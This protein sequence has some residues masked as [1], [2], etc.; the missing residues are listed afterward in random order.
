MSYQM[1][2]LRPT[3]LVDDPN[4]IHDW[5]T[6]TMEEHS[7]TVPGQLV[8]SINPVTSNTQAALSM[9]FYLLQITVLVA[10]TASLFQSFTISDLKNV[11]K[12]VLLKEYPYRKASG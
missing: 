6:Y 2:G 4:G 1:L 8:Q 11:P 3:S 12:I 7:F 9:P 5:R 10:L